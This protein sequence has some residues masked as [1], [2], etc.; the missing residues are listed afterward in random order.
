[1]SR[2]ES[3][4]GVRVTAALTFVTDQARSGG[5][6]YPVRSRSQS[7]GRALCG[8]RRRP[9]TQARERG[10]MASRHFSQLRASLDRLCSHGPEHSP[11]STSSRVFSRS[12]R[13]NRLGIV[14]CWLDRGRSRRGVGR[15]AG[16]V[17]AR[18]TRRLEAVER[19]R[20]RGEYRDR[21]ARFSSALYACQTCATRELMWFAVSDRGGEGCRLQAIRPA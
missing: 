17:A 8:Q 7:E 16:R 19:L 15:R 3:S 9:D 4:R 10:P 1:M 2:S 12:P 21:G 5:R 13:R 14:R 11:A 20:F 6:I 18:S